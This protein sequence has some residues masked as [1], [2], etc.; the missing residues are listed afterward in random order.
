MKVSEKL[1]VEWAVDCLERI[2]EAAS[3]LIDEL[4]NARNDMGDKRFARLEQ[5]IPV[6][7]NITTNTIISIRSL[8]RE[9]LD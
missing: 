7:T 3:T 9:F 6:L 2:A 8:A 5:S 1:K 4:D